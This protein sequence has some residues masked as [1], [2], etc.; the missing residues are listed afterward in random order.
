VFVLLRLRRGP[1][2]SDLPGG[3]LLEIQ[4]GAL[5]VSARSR[6]HLDSGT[7]HSV[8]SGP[9]VRSTPDQ[10]S[11]CAAASPIKLP[12]RCVRRRSDARAI[13]AP[14]A[15]EPTIVP[16]SSFCRPD[17]DVLSSRFRGLSLL[18]IESSQIGTEVAG[19]S[20]EQNNRIE[21]ALQFAPACARPGFFT[22]IPCR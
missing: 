19:D 21:N 12:R 9:R 16:I 8:A 11:R 17:P 4:I 18:C 20:V 10:S 2:A 1:S 3:A 14:A 7:G 6:H 22:L 13:P 5:N 15:V